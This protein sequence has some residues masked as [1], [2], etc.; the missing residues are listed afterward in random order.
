MVKN[1]VRFLGLF[2]ALFLII[3]QPLAEAQNTASIVLSVDNGLPKRVVEYSSTQ[4]PLI[5]YSAINTSGS[6]TLEIYRATLDDLL[7]YLTHDSKYQQLHPS[8]DTTKL[9]PL[10]SFT[11]DL[12]SNRQSKSLPL[13]KSGIYYLRLKLGDLTSETFAVRSTFG[14]LAREA[15]DTF[16][17]WNQDFTT[18]RSLTSGTVMLYS[19]NGS[20]NVVGT[21]SFDGDGVASLPLRADADLAVVA[22]ND[23]FSVIPFNIK[24]LGN[25][26][27]WLSYNQRAAASR[28]FL[29]TDRP[30]YRPGDTVKFKAVI[31]DDDDARYSLPSGPVLVKLFKDW[32]T[33]HPLN[34]QTLTLDNYGSVNG[35][36]KIPADYSSGLYSL[37]L[38][39]SGYETSGDNYAANNQISFRVE[40]YRK[41]DYT[42]SAVSATADL[43][44][45][46]TAT[47][48]IKGEYFSGYPLKNVKLTYK[49][50]AADYGYFDGETYYP[51]NGNYYYHSW[52]GDVIKEGEVTFNDQGLATV[53][54]KTNE[55][56][57]KGHSQS[58]YIE[59]DYADATGNSTLTGLNVL[60]R[61]GEFGIYRF[62]DV[63]SG[64]P[65]EKISLP[66]VYKSFRD[67]VSLAHPLSVNITRHW[68]EKY[69]DDNNKY[70]QYRENTENA[71]Q[72][73]LDVPGSGET[74]LSFTPSAEGS[75]QVK[76]STTDARGNYIE[77]IFY[78]WISQDAARF[79]SSYSLVTN[80]T[81][82]TDKKSYLPG[83]TVTAKITSATPDRDIFFAVERG[84]QDRYQIVHLN[85][86]ATTI[87]LPLADHDLP[88]VYLTVRSFGSDRLDADGHNV[89]ISTD[90]KKAFFKITT[91]KS[92][93]GPGDEVTAQI[94]ST[95]LAGK[96][97]PATMALW[98]VDKAIF[99]LSDKNYG[100]IF[101]AFWSERYDGT[102]EDNSLEGL[103]NGGAEKGG[104]FLAGTKITLA[105][106]TSKNIEDIKI[107]DT[108]LSRA[109]SNGPNTPQKVTALHHTSAPGYVILNGT[110]RLTPNHLLM[111][112][113]RW[114]QA[115]SVRVGDLL[116]DVSGQPIKVNSV[117]WQTGQ[118]PVYNFTVDEA[119]TYFADSVLV[120]N[121]K[122]DGDA[123]AHFDDTAYWNPT[124]VTDNNGI[125]TV[126]FKLPDNL[127]T[128]VITTIG[129]STDT[130]VGDAFTEI[131]TSKEL[132]IRPVL[133]N[134]LRL[135][136]EILVSALVNNYTSQDLVVDAS[137]K[138]DA[139]EL[140]ESSNTSRVSVKAGEYTEVGW[141][142]NIN[143]DQ[144]TASFDFIA[145][146]DAHHQD[147]VITSLPVRPFGYWQPTS[148]FKADN[149]T[150]LV[151]KPDSIDPKKSVLTLDL[152][153]TLFGSLPSAMRY[154][155]NYPYGC[156]E[157]TTS[158][159]VP[160]IL[161]QKY[162]TQFGD[163]LQDLTPKHGIDEGVS[164]LKELQQPDGGW[165][166][167]HGSSNDFVTAYVVEVLNDARAAGFTVDDSLLAQAQSY[168]LSGYDSLP[169]EAK[170]TRAYGLSFYGSGSQKI[171][172]QDLG[173]LPDDLLSL[174]VITNLKN[175][176]Q[177]SQ[178]NGLSLLLSRAKRT[179]T[180]L[181][182]S[183]SSVDK[184]GSA[185]ASTA[186]AIRALTLAGNHDQ[187][188]ASA[189]NYLVRHRSFD[190]WSNTFAT[191]EV[192][193]AV[194]GYQRTLTPATN[195]TVTLDGRQ[196][197]TGSFSATKTSVTV[198]L[199]PSQVKP[200]SRLLVSKSGTDPLY[201][202]FNQKWWVNSREA[203]S[204][205]HGFAITK[206]YENAKG[207]N[208]NLSPGDL[209]KVTLT[210]NPADSSLVDYGV[211]ED[212]LPS[213][214]VPVITTLKN[215]TQDLQANTWANEYTENG[216][217]IPFYQS[218][219]SYTYYAR[220]V[221]PGNFIA[222]PAF[223]T[224]M[225]HPEVWG[226][227]AFVP[228]T[229]DT[230][231]HLSPLSSLGPITRQLNYQ[232]LLI[233]VAV[234]LAA[235]LLI[236]V[237]LIGRH[238][239]PP[240]PPTA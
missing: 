210:I 163:S 169:V 2:I 139:G 214:L 95:D 157:Q 49:V 227:S 124:V 202:T 60:V 134:I 33:D 220:V 88:N 44:R 192:L 58:F 149:L 203:A 22:A 69:H 18:H 87:Q 226:R 5:E 118:V 50:Y 200:G 221:N 108:V 75:Y 201:A 66:I 25:E 213:G 36:V 112:N 6:G 222:P 21:A 24:S 176:L 141:K 48:Q 129:A 168:L 109:A 237:I 16:V 14:S 127:T 167:W 190:Y 100:S 181:Y 204:V 51:N 128:W 19:L 133:P 175:G 155:V 154:L 153:S 105:D 86:S 180:T 232:Q 76:T 148:Q 93:Y 38:S 187:D 205:N 219:T 103:Y 27:F 161:A 110:L 146:D 158:A 30:I 137:L 132:V 55:N 84:Y 43:V 177:D 67:N 63:Y 120:H 15:K 101:D 208:Y 122:G 92:S 53:N 218:T 77:K 126:K 188:I 54:I 130:K 211:I 96:P 57:S 223:V 147:E 72:F 217:Q 240:L 23:S 3:H 74:L 65:G 178:R 160:K 162:A 64:K 99:E 215:S 186:L 191:S 138:T 239:A 39:R 236:S 143:K 62:G 179:D 28:Y 32:N 235:L 174:A 45:G 82:N 68:W 121:D 195:Y 70:D 193:K 159:L 233:T 26:Y 115:G 182:W 196:I 209:V 97:V 40:N 98:A 199:D 170:V 131:K 61:A 119:H 152:S 111:V 117:E 11:V 150:F 142:Y 183:A 234:L 80:L 9:T 123:R 173:K 164:K 216:V 7:T 136:D 228:V 102:L 34:S 35:T 29:F 71:G 107:G 31:R 172:D 1:A 73:T 91:D 17:V 81:I 231:I 135:G 230:N 94:T 225:Y 224:L 13:D 20:A 114:Q 171:I 113:R 198:T 194:L 59:F 151:D 56:D 8:V 10:T 12:N 185:D 52:S 140:V 189:L 37:L 46:D 184:F 106:G 165:S 85:G 83:Q 79:D 144:S 125:A 90:S 145:K 212:H 78:L 4:D 166:W 47:V 116:S 238:R 197:S 156:V 42:L 41:P 206:K 207:A 104:C 89:S 229:V